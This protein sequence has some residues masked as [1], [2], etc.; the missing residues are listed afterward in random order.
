MNTPSYF[1]NIDKIIELEGEPF[2]VNLF[3]NSEIKQILDFY[4][5]LPT[6][7]FNQI[8]KI[9]KK[10]WL[11]GNNYQLDT[12][13]KD[14][15]DQFL[16]NWEF[17]NMFSDEEAIGIFHESINPLKIHAD[18]GKN[19]KSIIYKQMLIPLSDFGETI[20]FEPRW[21]GE[22]SSFTINEEEI[23]SNQGYNKRT[24]I[25]IGTENFN[26]QIY[27][28]YLQHEDYNNLKG[29]KIKQIYKWKIGEAF[30]FDRSFI[31]C[32]STLTKPK[33][34]L[35]IFFIYKEKP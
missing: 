21:R 6:A 30:I 17:D 16:S 31:H 8:Q 13:L 22:A 1:T 26:K 33:I 12:L 35:T 2:I 25:H 11:V 29:L 5:T 14:K 10:H 19:K 7:V 32:S 34:G 27:D 28:K 23:N 9:K 18:T 20:L 24:N 3:S 4:V 15:I